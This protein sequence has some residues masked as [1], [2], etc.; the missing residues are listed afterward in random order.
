M[1]TLLFVIAAL[2][3]V[4][5]QGCFPLVAAGV[6]AGALSITDRRSTGAQL[7]DT[8]IEMKISNRFKEQFGTA[9]YTAD[10]TSFNRR[11]LLTGEVESEE[12][13]KKLTEIATGVPNVAGVTNEMSVGFANTRPG[14]ALITSNVKAR[15]LTNNE[16]RFSPN[17]VKVVTEN[18]TV[19][20]LGLVT[21]AEADAATEVARTSKGV[22]RVVKVFEYVDKAPEVGTAA[23]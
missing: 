18:S 14:D 15:F 3:I 7:D 10:I 13:K 12:I 6:G 23:Q 21:T 20:L 16:G 5:L 11:V 22:Q 1:R 2:I 4:N 17:H 19:Y 9:Q 8:A